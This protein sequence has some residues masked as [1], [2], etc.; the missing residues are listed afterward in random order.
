MGPPKEDPHGPSQGGPHEPPQGGLPSPQGGPSRPP[1]PR[2]SKVTKKEREKSRQV[3][4]RME[5]MHAL[6]RQSSLK[7]KG[8]YQGAKQADM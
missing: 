7:R 2:W 3:E 8:E 1:G 6:E 4:K 5:N